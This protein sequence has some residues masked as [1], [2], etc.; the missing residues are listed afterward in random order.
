MNQVQ[1]FLSNHLV[2][3]DPKQVNLG[4]QHLVL[5]DKF[6]YKLRKKERRSKSLDFEICLETNNT[7]ANFYQCLK[8]NVNL[9]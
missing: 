8:T 3:Y 2:N 9:Y 7:V 4:K 5:N 6:K 1:T